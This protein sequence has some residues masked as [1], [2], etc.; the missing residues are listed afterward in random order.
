MSNA[1][2]RRHQGLF[3]ELKMAIS[4]SPAMWASAVQLADYTLSVSLDSCLASKGKRKAG[5]STAG[6]GYGKAG[7]DDG[8]MGFCIKSG[9]VACGSSTAV[10]VIF[11]S[12]SLSLKAKG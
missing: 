10:S 7:P 1:G 3:T 6:Q 12:L 9:R 4:A 5:R 8:R 11:L 2:E